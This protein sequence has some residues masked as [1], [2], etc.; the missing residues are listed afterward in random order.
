MTLPD[1][2]LELPLAHRALHD[3]A[4]GCVEN[5]LSAITA[6]IEAGFG[7]EIDV[8]LAADGVAMVFH[9]R[10]LDRLTSETG[11][12]RTRR[13]ID[14]GR[15]ELSGGG[16]GIPT[17]ENALDAIDGRTPILIEIKDR[18]E[19]LNADV[20]PLERA[21]AGVLAKY[22]GP[23]A[24]MSF[25]PHSTAM[26]A[27]LIPEL[28]R[29][30]VTTRFRRADWPLVSAQRRAALTMIA[31]YERVGACFISHRASDLRSPHVARLKAAGAGVLC[32]TIRTPEAEAEARRIANNI[33]FEGYRP[34]TG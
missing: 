27:R 1:V 12:I 32:W 14:L 15:I 25:N 23:S 6:A 4:R 10:D 20:G 5:S 34:A 26:M 7:I 8:Q 30:L 24:V 33:T 17:L 9:D 11:P 22:E 28:P 29:G 18:D 31:D 21:V 16:E 3:R 19:T 13:S 2:F